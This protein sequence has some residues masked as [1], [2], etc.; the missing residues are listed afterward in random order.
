MSTYNYGYLLAAL[1][2]MIYAI[3]D[4][5]V[6]FFVSIYGPY[7]VILIRTSSQFACLCAIALWKGFHP[8]KTQRIGANIMRAVLATCATYS[9]IIA[10]QNAP[11]TSVVVISHSYA[12]FVIPLSVILL[13]EKFSWQRTLIIILGFIGIAVMFSPS[14]ENDGTIGLTFALL[15]SIA[16]ALN[17]VFLKNLSG[18]EKTITVIFYHHVCLILSA[19]VLGIN[20]LQPIQISHILML[21]CGGMIGLFAQYLVISSY[22]FTSSSNLASAAY[23][24]LIPSIIIDIVFYDKWPTGYVFIGGVLVIYSCYMASKQR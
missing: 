16:K 23:A 12:M 2:S 4:A 15:A 18:T 17:H 11:M 22:R 14:N 9:L 7:Q 8:A 13:H 19:F 21:C 6:K 24:I 1:G 10:Y 3:S 20:N 5:I